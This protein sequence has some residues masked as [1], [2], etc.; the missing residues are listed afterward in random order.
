MWYLQNE[1]SKRMQPTLS[2]LLLII[3]VSFPAFVFARHSSLLTENKGQVRNQ[4]LE[5]RPDIQYAMHGGDVSVFIGNGQLHYQWYRSLAGNGPDLTPD[6]QKDEKT[7]IYR[8]DVVLLGAN[9]NAPVLAEGKGRD[10]ELYYKP[11]LPFDGVTV[12]G[13]QKI[14]YKNIY[15]NIDWVLYA[16]NGHLKYDFIVH[17]GGKVSDIRLQYTGGETSLGADGAITASTPFGSITEQKPYS[18]NVETKQT[19]VSAFVLKENIL[20]FDLSP[21]SGTVVIDPVVNWITYYGGNE[22]MSGSNFQYEWMPAVASDAAGNAYVAG[23]SYASNNIATTGAFQTTY[24]GWRDG[25]IA[26]FDEQGVRQWGTYY[27][28]NNSDCFGGIDLDPSGNIFAAGPTTSA[29]LATPGAH[30]TSGQIIIAKF[31]NNG[32]RIWA[33]YHS[34]SYSYGLNMPVA[35][36]PSGNVYIAHSFANILKLTGAGAFGWDTSMY[37]A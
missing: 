1:Y 33:T 21:Y 29:G 14:S 26:K 9:T 8:M 6:Q 18:Y 31:T 15:P 35:C 17:P 20:S 28:G 27:G 11:Y 19:V 4:F 5:A 25:F 37:P 36:D 13:Y 16:D 10:Y 23:S 3:L 32:A 22:V 30:K 24:A 2:K 12:Y 7:E 34:M